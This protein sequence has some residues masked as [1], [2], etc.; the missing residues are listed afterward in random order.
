MGARSR[1]LCGA[2]GVLLVSVLR[3]TAAGLT[4]AGALS[5]LAVMVLAFSLLYRCEDRAGE[6][7][8]INL[9]KV[10]S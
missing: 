3:R 1:F 6:C 5:L 8:L 10:V 9:G 2:L 4:F 7:W